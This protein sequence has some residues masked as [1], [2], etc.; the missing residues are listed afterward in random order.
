[1]HQIKN[2]IYGLHF[3]RCKLILTLYSAH[4]VKQHRGLF[5]HSVSESNSEVLRGSKLA[6]YMKAIK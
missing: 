1:M 5:K 3:P 6:H 2:E 4:P